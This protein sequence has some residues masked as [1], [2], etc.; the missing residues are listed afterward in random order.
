MDIAS[1]RAASQTCSGGQGFISEVYYV[2]C[3]NEK[4]ITSQGISQA[5]S[6]ILFS[7]Y[8]SNIFPIQIV[9]VYYFAGLHLHLLFQCV[10]NNRDGKCCLLFTLEFVFT[11][12]FLSVILDANKD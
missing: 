8:C 4:A 1:A 9:P 12:T 5:I 3:N 2:C 11:K 7:T 10:L 6:D